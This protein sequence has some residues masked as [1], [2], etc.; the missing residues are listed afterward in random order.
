MVAGIKKLRGKI[1]FRRINI[2]GTIDSRRFK[3]SKNSPE[4]S[5]KNPQLRN[6]DLIIVDKSLINVTNEIIGE[7]TKPFVGIY[8]SIKLFD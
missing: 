1:I 5:Y 6:G 3:F 7:V 8:S 4:G 2:D